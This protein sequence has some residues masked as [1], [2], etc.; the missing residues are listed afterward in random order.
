MNRA[1][2]VGSYRRFLSSFGVSVSR[3][4]NASNYRVGPTG[5]SNSGRRLV[6]GG[7][8]PFFLEGIM[9]GPSEKVISLQG[10]ADEYFRAHDAMLR[11]SKE[12]REARSR[13]DGL[14]KSLGKRALKKEGDRKIF[15]S[16]D[17]RILVVEWLEGIDDD[18]PYYFSVEVIHKEPTR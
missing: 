8:A 5:S 15:A 3:A 2:G 14:E 13:V 17:Q 7:Q 10:L 1:R 9:P 12:E 4:F 6:S 18:D 16:K 11:L